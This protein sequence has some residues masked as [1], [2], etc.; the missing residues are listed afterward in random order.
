MNRDRLRPIEKDTLERL[1]RLLEFAEASDDNARALTEHL[2]EIP[3]TLNQL[4]PKVDDLVEQSRRAYYI[5]VASAGVSVVSLIL[6]IAM[7][8]SSRRNHRKL[9]I[10]TKHSKQAH[11]ELVNSSRSVEKAANTLTGAIAAMANK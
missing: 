10:L 9:T 2:L 6:N 1:D 5:A 11:Q 3:D 8:R 7:V 4:P